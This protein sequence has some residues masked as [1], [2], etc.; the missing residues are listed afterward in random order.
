[1]AD[2]LIMEIRRVVSHHLSNPFAQNLSALVGQLEKDLSATKIPLDAHHARVL[3]IFFHQLQQSLTLDSKRR[4]DFQLNLNSLLR[5]LEVELNSI[6][7]AFGQSVQQEL[8][9]V[10]S[11]LQMQDEQTNRQRELLHLMIKDLKNEVNI[12][13]K[14][15]KALKTRLDTLEYSTIW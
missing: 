8:G 1:M 6:Q 3:Q 10:R 11:K 7:D 4:E 5:M 15:E 14:Q 13:R 2:Q 12:S 9:E